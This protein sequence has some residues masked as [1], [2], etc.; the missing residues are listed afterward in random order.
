M[1]GHNNIQISFYTDINNTL[2]VRIFE[3]EE[4]IEALN[5]KNKRSNKRG[6]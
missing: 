4:K 3:L 2:R 5:K 6:A 1:I